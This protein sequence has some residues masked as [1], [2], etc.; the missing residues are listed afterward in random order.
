MLQI[1]RMLCL[2]YVVVKEFTLMLKPIY[3]TLFRRED[4]ILSVFV[5]VCV[6]NKT[7]LLSRVKLKKLNKQDEPNT[8]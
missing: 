5:F 7:G 2:Q 6:Q 1:I 8:F 4:K 3:I